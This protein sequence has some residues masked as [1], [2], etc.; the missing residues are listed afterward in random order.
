MMK[1]KIKKNTNVQHNV[2][3]PEHLELAK[4]IS[5]QATVLLQNN[6]NFLP[7]SKSLKTILVAGSQANDPIVHGG[8]SG[9][10]FP[11]SVSTPLDA[12][13]ASVVLFVLIVLCF[14][15]TLLWS[16]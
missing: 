4:Q 9:Q 10:V 12:I 3:S 16:F 1:L 7:L 11:D 6:N 5:A 14:L 2:T 13:R 15:F 8:G